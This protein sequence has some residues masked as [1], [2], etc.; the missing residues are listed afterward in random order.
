MSITSYA[1]P[2]IMLPIDYYVIAIWSSVVGYHV[3][4][5][6]IVVVWKHVLH[7]FAS[8]LGTEY[9]DNCLYYEQMGV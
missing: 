5:N 2:T 4:A 9:I 7:L 1:I 3:K 6:T 8:F